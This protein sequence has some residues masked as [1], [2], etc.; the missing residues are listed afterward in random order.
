MAYNS[1]EVLSF[2]I[3]YWASWNDMIGAVAGGFFFLIGFLPL[4][5]I[6]LI[7][8]PLFGEFM[9]SWGYAFFG[10]GIRQ[11]RAAT[12]PFYLMFPSWDLYNPK[13]LGYDILIYWLT[14]PLNLVLGW[15]FGTNIFANIFGI[16][17]LATWYPG[18]YEKGMWDNK[19]T[20]S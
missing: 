9:N 14:T 1:A 7:A 8:V 17:W 6:F 15:I 4:E 3:S 10:A 18:D 12:L 2:Y 19:W 16:I 5:A 13:N 20:T 11:A